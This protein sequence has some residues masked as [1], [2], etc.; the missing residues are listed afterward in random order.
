MLETT[1]HIDLKVP[2]GWN[3]CTTEQL[4]M[5]ALTMMQHTMMQNRYQPFDWT[6]VKTELFFVF[7]G[8][9]IVGHTEGLARR[10]EGESQI[11]ESTERVVAS[12]KKWQSTE[13]TE[14][15]DEFIVRFADRRPWWKK[16]FSFRSSLST[17]PLKVW[18]VQSWIDQHLSW[19]DDDKA[20]PLL[21]FPYKQLIYK[22]RWP[23]QEKQWLAP[24]ELLQNFSWEQYRHLQDYMDLYIKLQN[25]LVQMQSKAVEKSKIADLHAQINEART[26]FLKVLFGITEANETSNLRSQI[27]NLNDIQWQ[28]ILFWWSGLMRYLQQQFPRCFKP[29]SKGSKKSQPSNPLELYIS[30]TATMQKYL[31]LDEDKVNRQTFYLTLEQLERMSKESEELERISKRNK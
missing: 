19:I 31:S 10:P 18:Q 29:A 2:T 7:A 28:V 9:D 1:R 8:L 27:S 17:F 3:Q 20:Q 25:Q 30:I 4:E 16:L 14:G 26:N 22:R 5:I 24:E 21:L 6:A 12:D 15:D 13:S 11:T 23:W